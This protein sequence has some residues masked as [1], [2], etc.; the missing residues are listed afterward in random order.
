[1]LTQSIR[2]GTFS[3]QERATATTEED[4]AMMREVWSRK[5]TMASGDAILSAMT[6]AT[7]L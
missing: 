3:G 7:R 5:Q 4:P 2:L 1:M 6:D